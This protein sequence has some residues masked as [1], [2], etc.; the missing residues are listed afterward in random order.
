[1]GDAAGLRYLPLGIGNAFSAL[2]YTCCIALE[3]AG[4]WMLVDCPH[5]LRK[6]LREGSQ[7]AGVSLDIPQIDLALITHLHADHASGL[8]GFGFFHHFAL[9]SRA[10]VA[11]HPEVAK[12][13]WDDKLAGSM[14]LNCDDHCT[15]IFPA[16]FDQYFDLSLVTEEEPL[17]SGPFRIECRKTLHPIPTVAFRVHAGGKTLSISGDTYFDPT[18][19]DWLAEGDLIIHEAGAPPHAPYEDLAGLPR[20][21]LDR[22]RL[23][24]LPDAFDREAS[25][26]EALE[27]GR[28]Y[29]V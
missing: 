15:E 12:R 5:P 21:I 29:E 10:P 27:E 18:L 26:I 4:R 20:E 23:I 24:H 1:M 13:M 8:E 14:D 22:M 25:V 3:C 11:T 9:G 19:I 2:H 16:T 6:L 17:T 7:K 28:L